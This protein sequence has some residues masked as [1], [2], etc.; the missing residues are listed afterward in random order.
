M[1]QWPYIDAS[2]KE[3]VLNQLDSSLSDKGANGI[4]CAAEEALA[5][6]YGSKYAV[7]FSSATGA[8]HSLTFA[9]GLNA[10]D[11]VIVPSYTFFATFSPFAY[12]GQKIVQCDCDEYG[13]IS[14][15]DV[16]R[17]ITPRTKAVVCTHMW[18]IPS[19][20]AALRDI[21]EQYGLALIEDGSHAHVATYG[22]RLVG[23]FG[24]ASVF[25]TN[26]KFL[27]S[28]EGGFLLTDKR[29]IYERAILF[30]HYNERA[31]AQIECEALKPYALTGLGLKYRAT[32]LSAAILIN[33]LGK[34]RDIEQ[35]R[36]KIYA[37]FQQ[38]VTQNP[39]LFNIAPPYIWESGLYVFPF[40][41]KDREVRDRFLTFADAR[42]CN[43]FD[44]PGS[45]KPLFDEPMFADGGAAAGRQTLPMSMRA[46][47]T[48]STEDFPGAVRFHDRIVKCPM[49]G[50]DGDE[51]DVTMCETILKEFNHASLD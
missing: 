34:M 28:G 50:Y 1:Y 44:A 2:L 37:R 38:A 41:A 23:N 29:A 16:V 42:G 48:D 46:A 30:A 11:E 15:K 14:V 27:T 47:P 9:L 36:R 8:M 13:Q 4:I 24:D 33:Q 12:E 20:I 39:R 17:K 6:F 26:Q 22:Q 5:E 25:S 10:G 3:A 43:Y 40:L 31:K 21:C 7:F 45:T 19:D 49:W 18:G 32:T 51:T 35:R